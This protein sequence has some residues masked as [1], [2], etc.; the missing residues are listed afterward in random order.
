[1][2]TSLEIKLRRG[3]DRQR[4]FSPA[5]MELMGILGTGRGGGVVLMRA[6]GLEF[7]RVF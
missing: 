3:A 2:L 1:M 7:C 4:P 6:G 5:V